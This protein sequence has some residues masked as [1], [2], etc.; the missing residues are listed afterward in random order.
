MALTLCV[1]LWAWPGKEGL[2]NDYEDQVLGLLGRH[3]ARV[4]S[5]VRAL[6][7][8]PSEMQILEFASERALVDF[9]NDPARL[10]LATLRDSAIER[11]QVIRVEHV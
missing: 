4:L 5:R 1:L 3:G 6:E 10:V 9:Q 11:T 2:L 7:A 8:G